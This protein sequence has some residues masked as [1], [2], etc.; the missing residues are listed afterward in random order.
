MAV[1][2]H[3]WEVTTLKLRRVG[4]QVN[5]EA[6]LLA[7]YTERLLAAGGT[8]PAA[9]PGRAQRLERDWLAQHGWG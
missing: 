6:D 1:I 2:P 8:P 5:L 4:D 7:K 9:A 3:T